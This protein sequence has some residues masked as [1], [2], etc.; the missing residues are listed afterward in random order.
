MTNVR[1]RNARTL[2]DRLDALTR[3][4]RDV[5]EYLE[6][7]ADAGERAPTLDEICAALDVRSR[8]SMHKHITALVSAE[9]V[10]PLE[11]R[12]RGVRLASGSDEA[13]LPLLGVIAA[14]RPIEAIVDSE[15]IDV[16]PM[17][18]TE[19]PCYVLRVKGESMID[20]GILDGDLVVVEHRDHARNGEIVVALIDDGEATLKRIFQRPTEIELLPANSTMRSMRYSP[21]R[22]RI[23]GVVVGQM[24]MYR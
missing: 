24:R 13:G 5:Y 6:R 15:S 9:L 1:T 3:R 18:K 12:H 16:P 8:G 17:L 23:Q 14:G 11:G 19:R 4:Q 20:D 22:V 21:E 2:E 7:R 10:D